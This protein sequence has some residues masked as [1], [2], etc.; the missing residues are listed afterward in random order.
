MEIYLNPEEQI[1]CPYNSAH[2]IR[3]KVM[4]THLVKCKKNYPEAKLVE[5]DF[6]VTHKIPEPELQYHH[7]NCPDRK[8]IEV[9]IYQEDKTNLNKF[10][11]HNI[12]ISPE[13]NWDTENVDTYKPDIY[14]E[15]REV[16]R[17]IDVQS[18]AK[19]RNFRLGERQRVSE[20]QKERANKKVVNQSRPIRNA[21]LSSFSGKEL[22]ATERTRTLEEA[23]PDSIGEIVQRIRIGANQSFIP[24]NK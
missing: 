3:R 11:I 23:T 18:A 6:N 2:F 1:M 10:P 4:N 16:L 13:D 17:H 9:T 21:A 24:K 7:D 5:C 19:R 22:P 8:K 20:V 12:H 15:T 14:C